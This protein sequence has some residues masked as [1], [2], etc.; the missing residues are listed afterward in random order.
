MAAPIY[1][2]VLTGGPCGGKSTTLALLDVE[3]EVT[4]DDRYANHAIALG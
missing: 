4:H 2:L 1:R 3:G